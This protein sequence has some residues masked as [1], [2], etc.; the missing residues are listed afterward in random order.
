[1]NFMRCFINEAGMIV[2]V[3]V[4]LVPYAFVA[5][6]VEKVTAY[7]PNPRPRH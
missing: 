1:M 5:V 2:F 6:Y 7:D 4:K 3:P